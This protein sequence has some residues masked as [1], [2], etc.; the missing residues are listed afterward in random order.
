MSRFPIINRLDAAL[1]KMAF[2]RMDVRAI[3]LTVEDHDALDR[4]ESARWKRKVSVLEYEGHEIRRGNVS[5]IYSTHGVEIV[6]PK[7][8]SMKA[9]A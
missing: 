2:R 5:K 6:V 8:L 9:A 1:E 4:A 3:Y 7:R